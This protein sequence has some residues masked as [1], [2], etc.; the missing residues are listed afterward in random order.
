MIKVN[1]IGD[2]HPREHALYGQRG[3]A[4]ISLSSA[5]AV[6]EHALGDG[7]CVVFPDGGALLIDER[8]EDLMSRA[9]ANDDMAQGDPQARAQIRALIPITVALV[10]TLDF[11]HPG[12]AKDFLA[13]SDP[14]ELI[15]HS[16]PEDSDASLAI[17]RQTVRQIHAA[18]SALANR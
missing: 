14:D 7:A 8:V 1:V 4:W 9:A 6:Y 10:S 16:V 13:A 11:E 2:I 12:I 17:A 15:I 5:V 18:I 3:E